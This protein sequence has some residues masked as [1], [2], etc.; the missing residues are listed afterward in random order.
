L[1][2]ADLFGLEFVDYTEETLT[3]V[4]RDNLIVYFLGRSFISWRRKARK[5]GRR[6]AQ[7]FCMQQGE[8]TGSRFRGELETGM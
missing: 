3:L 8:L 6:N 4:A 5:L 7:R 2:A 1:G